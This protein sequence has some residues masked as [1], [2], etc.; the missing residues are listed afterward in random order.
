[1]GQRSKADQEAWI[2]VEVRAPRWAAWCVSVG[3]V[4]V[5]MSGVA[6]VALRW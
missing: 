4:L 2:A 3:S 5:G 1:M 6:L